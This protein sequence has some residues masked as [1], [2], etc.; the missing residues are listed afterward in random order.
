ME[1]LT[2]AEKAI[3]RKAPITAKADP[4]NKIFKNLTQVMNL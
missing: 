4:D 1:N 3:R 2:F